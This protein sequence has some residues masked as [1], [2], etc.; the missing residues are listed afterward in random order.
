MA[1]GAAV[2]AADDVYVAD[3][4]ADR[5]VR[6]SPDGRVNTPPALAA[7]RVENPTGVAPGRGDTPY[8][9]AYPSGGIQVWRIVGEE[10]TRLYGSMSLARRAPTFVLPFLLGLLAVALIRRRVTRVR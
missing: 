4:G 2:D 5:I 1:M 10:R 6:F 8:V 9:L 3:Y 7:A